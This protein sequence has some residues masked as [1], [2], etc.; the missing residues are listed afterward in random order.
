MTTVDGHCR[1]DRIIGA[2]E[3]CRSVRANADSRPASG[4]AISGA[5][6]TS[7]T[8]RAACPKAAAVAG[9]FGFGGMRLG[10]GAMI[11]LVIVGMLFG[12]NPFEM[13][14][15]MGG[16]SGPVQAPPQQ[17][18]PPGYGPQ[19]ARPRRAPR[20]PPP[21]TAISRKPYSATP[22]TSGARSS[23]RWASATSRR[24]SFSIAAATRSAC[25]QASAAVGPF[26]CPADH[27]LLSRHVVLRRTAQPLRRARRL[28]AGVRDRARSRP[29]RAEPARHDAP[30]RRA[31][32]ARATSARATRCRCASS[33][34]PTATR[35]SGASSQKRTSSTPTTSTAVCV[36]RR[37]SAT[38]STAG[39]RRLVHARLG[40]AACTLVPD[41]PAV[42]RPRDCNTFERADV[43]A[44]PMLVERRFRARALAMTPARGAS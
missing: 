8:A 32:A 28:R 4:G 44:R 3:T 6:T 36:P 9:G 35:A 29:P 10:G 33:C 17:S 13:L 19:T 1:I 7:R 15:M 26:Y 16:D 5:A 18:A 40:R 12:I 42:G 22:R 39:C 31:V 11:I 30:V 24:S 34:R 41:G 2:F 21:S 14:G 20:R 43:A 27:E 38:I 37:P 25:G 23:R